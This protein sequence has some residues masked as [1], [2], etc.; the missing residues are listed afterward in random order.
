MA[1][2][3]V[4]TAYVTEASGCKLASQQVL[5]WQCLEGLFLLKR[6]VPADITVT[7]LHLAHDISSS[8]VF[9]T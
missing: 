6:H 9:D 5:Q 2:P 3:W 4:I 1:M 7:C 8:I